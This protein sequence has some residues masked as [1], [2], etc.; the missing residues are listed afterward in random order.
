MFEAF[1][2]NDE[3]WLRRFRLIAYETW[4]KG[5]KNAVSME[6]YMPIG[7]EK[8]RDMTEAELDEVWLKY[9]KLNKKNK[10]N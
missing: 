5:A 2:L 9:G 10:L 1:K 4:R 6:S 3:V 7:K 8:G